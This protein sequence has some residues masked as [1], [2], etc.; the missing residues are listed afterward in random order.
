MA[1]MRTTTAAAAL[2]AVVAGLLAGCA[3]GAADEARPSAS[4]TAAADRADA[5]DGGA[6]AAGGAGG[7]G[8]PAA[9]DARGSDRAGPGD[10]AGQGAA[11][12]APATASE[13]PAQ[14]AP[15][16]LPTLP[17]PEA[18]TQ[19]RLELPLPATAAAAGELVAGFPTDIV[20]L[21][22]GAVVVTSSVSGQG[23]RLQVALDASSAEPPA[24]VVAFYRAAFAAAGFVAESPPTAEGAVAASF[25]RGGDGVVVSVR[26]A[27]GGGSQIS[28]AGVLRAIT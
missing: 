26:T 11:A 22:T 28:V 5:A 4:S 14:S 8:G 10:D 2:A 15:F 24:D 3:S 27:Q 1:I 25:T 23:D 9:P 21:S 16:A 13:V 7:S 12:D 20:P 19:A 17:T 6:E 18:P